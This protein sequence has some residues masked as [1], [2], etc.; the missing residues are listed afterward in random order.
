MKKISDIQKSALKRLKS[1]YFLNVVI[2][3]VMSIITTGGYNY[4]MINNI[5][6]ISNNSV[7]LAIKHKSNFEILDEF[8]NRRNIYYVSSPDTIARKYTKGVLSVFVNEITGTGSF[9]FGLLNGIN[10]ILFGGKLSESVTI[11]IMSLL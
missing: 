8:I 5:D 10:K 2:V 3:F 7:M 9:G 6:A 1:H 4:T 11:F